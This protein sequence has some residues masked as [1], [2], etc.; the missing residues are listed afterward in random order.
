MFAPAIALARD[1][2]LVTPRLRNALARSRRTGALS[3]E[4]RAVFYGA[5]GE[6]LAG[7]SRVRNPRLAAFLSDLSTRGP[8][9]F[10]VG[11]NAQAIATTVSRAPLNPA[12]MTTGDLAAYDA[13]PRARHGRGD[14]LCIGADI[15]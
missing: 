11:P 15:K 8:D 1:G 9:S 12:P 13:K 2:F 10:Y 14:R 6:P 4:A 3:A 7:G 5:D